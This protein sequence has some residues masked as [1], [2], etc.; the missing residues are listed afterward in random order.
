VV[1]IIYITTKR[2]LKGALKTKN[3][4]GYMLYEACFFERCVFLFFG[5][6][7]LTQAKYRAA[8]ATQKQV[9]VAR[10][11]PAPRVSISIEPESESP[12]RL[13][14]WSWFAY[15]SWGFKIQ[16]HE[17]LHTNFGKI[18][19]HASPQVHACCRFSSNLWA[20]VLFLFSSVF[21]AKPLSVLYH[22]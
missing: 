9:P 8:R 12:G 10:S 5:G 2:H 16:I 4:Q 18:I 22:P 3:G 11:P 6:G 20:S 14:L 1:F 17:A 21:R 7:G 15:S 13:G 19:R